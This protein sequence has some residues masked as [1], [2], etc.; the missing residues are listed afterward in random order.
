LVRRKEGL[1]RAAPVHTLVQKH[2]GG[3]FLARGRVL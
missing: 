3:M 1:E 2:A